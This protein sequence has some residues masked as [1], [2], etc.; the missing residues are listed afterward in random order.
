MRTWT[1]NEVLKL[2]QPQWKEEKQLVR[3]LFIYSVR[4]E[5]VRANQINKRK[6]REKRRGPAC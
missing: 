5:N 1:N 4:V 6:C 3:D 2:G